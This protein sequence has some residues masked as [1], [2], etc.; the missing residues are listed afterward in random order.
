[1]SLESFTMTESE[2]L[3]KRVLGHQVSAPDKPTSTS[4]PSFFAFAKAM[5]S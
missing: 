5:S 4:R 1:M 3:S 2:L